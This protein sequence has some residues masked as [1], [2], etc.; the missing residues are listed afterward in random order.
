LSALSGLLRLAK[1]S[2]VSSR[3]DIYSK[4]NDTVLKPLNGQSN[5]C[6]AIYIALA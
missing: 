1:S 6:G 4:Q 5:A 2:Q 3:S